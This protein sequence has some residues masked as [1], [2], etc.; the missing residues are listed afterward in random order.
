MEVD[1]T[2]FRAL[3]QIVQETVQRG[4]RFT[5]TFMAEHL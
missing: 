1:V 3:E 2:N 5:K 4:H